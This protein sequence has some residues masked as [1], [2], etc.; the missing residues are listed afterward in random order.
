MEH[1]PRTR[2]ARP[3]NTKPSKKQINAARMIGFSSIVAVYTIATLISP[4][5]TSRKAKPARTSGYTCTEHFR[6]PAGCDRRPVFYAATASGSMAARFFCL[7]LFMARSIGRTV[8]SV[9][10]SSR[11]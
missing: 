11:F 5:K 10:S 6:R 2:L 7:T 9:R 1:S 4:V 8:N 3:D